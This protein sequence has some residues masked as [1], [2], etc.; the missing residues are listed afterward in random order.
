MELEQ[1]RSR[2]IEEIVNALNTD[3]HWTACA[4]GNLNDVTFPITRYYA[5]GPNVVMVY[6]ASEPPYLFCHGGI[7]A[8]RL[9]L[10]RLPHG[11]Y[12]AA[13]TM[14]PEEIFPP[15]TKVVELKRMLRMKMEM[16]GK[17]FD[18]GVADRLEQKDVEAITELLSYFEGRSF[19]PEQLA[20]PHAGIYL[21]DRLVAMAGTRIV[22]PEQRVAC[23]D[24]VLVHPEFAERGFG[25]QVLGKVLELLA[26]DVDLVA[27]D[28]PVK[29]KPSIELYGR[30]GFTTHGRFNESWVTIP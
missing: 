8:L 16:A 12:L 2:D 13:F 7:G 5:N 20:Y 17:T 1:F 9:I 25:P 15:D 19:N 22:N 10:S 21:D 24:A 26:R 14:E 23:L 18:G 11:D 3:R 29:D 30:L 27:V 4:L 6:E 28:S